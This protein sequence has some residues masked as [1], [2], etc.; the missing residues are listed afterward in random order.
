MPD[1]R[2]SV[3]DYLGGIPIELQAVARELRRVIREVA[4]TLP[5]S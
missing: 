5:R 4:R 2:K 1:E 3:D